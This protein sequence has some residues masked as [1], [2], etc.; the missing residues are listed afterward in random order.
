M[1]KSSIHHFDKDG[2]GAAICALLAYGGID[3]VETTLGVVGTT[4]VG[5]CGGSG[6]AGGGLGSGRVTTAGGDCM[7]HCNALLERPGLP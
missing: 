5:C 1:I 6:G 7:V 4:L 3:T 2:G